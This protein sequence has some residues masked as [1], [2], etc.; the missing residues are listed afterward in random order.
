MR[1]LTA[2]QLE[3]PENL[4]VLRGLG[5]AQAYLNDYQ[6]S[7]ATFL[8]ALN[9]SSNDPV[10]LNNLGSV[11]E[12]LGQIEKAKEY[13]ARAQSTNGDNSGTAGSFKTIQR[14]IERLK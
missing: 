11:Y 7:E 1:Q 13:Y 12:G 8:K 14:N 2:L 6:A 5:L 4:D 3:N 10:I 9:I